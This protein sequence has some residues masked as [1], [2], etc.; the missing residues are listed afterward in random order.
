M[1]TVTAPVEGFTGNVIGVDF[2]DGVGE[3]DDQN[4]LNYFTRQGY[5]VENTGKPVSK[6]TKA[7]LIELAE[8]HDIEVNKAAKVDEIRSVIS[9]ALN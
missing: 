2:V 6:M 4:K 5:R 9:E 7:E 1:A 8:D 3:T